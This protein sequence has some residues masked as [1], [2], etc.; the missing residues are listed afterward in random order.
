MNE[1]TAAVDRLSRENQSE[2][3]KL[4]QLLNDGEEQ[5]SVVL[6]AEADAKAGAS[7]IGFS[8]AKVLEH[9]SRKKTLFID[10]TE[11]SI[12]ESLSLRSFGADGPPLL[13][14]SGDEPDGTPADP[15]ARLTKLR[16][17][18]AYVVI[19]AGPV[20]NAAG[21]LAIS[22]VVGCTFFIV[23]PGVSSRN[24]AR[25]GL[26]LLRRFGFSGISLI[27]NKRTSHVPDWM[28]RRV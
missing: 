22:G 13:K 5:G 12:Y 8:L 15:V 25:Y 17:E 3:A 24:S 4:Y 11:H 19:A 23:E 9:I 6:L 21:L 27:L 20:K 16:E 10:Q 7:L 2:F 18:Y 1:M 26:D 14:L 28:T